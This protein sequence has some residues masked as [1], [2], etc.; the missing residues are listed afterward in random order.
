MS[1]DVKALL[2]RVCRMI[3]ERIKPQVVAT[4][5]RRQADML[6][7][8]DSDYIPLTFPKYGPL[9]KDLPNFDFS[10]Q[11]HDPGMSLYTQLKDSVLPF[12]NNGADNVLGVRADM[13]VVNGMSLFGAKFAIPVHTRTIVTEYVPKEVLQDFV[14]P[15]DI[16]HLGTMPR[17]IEHSQHHLAVLKQYGLADAI[18]VHHC[19]TQGPFDIAA[20]TRGHDIFVD[21]YDDGPFVHRLMML[22]TQAYVAITKLCKKIEGQPLGRGNASGCWMENGSGRMCADSEILVS[23]ELHREFIQPYQ[24]KAFDAIGGGWLH[25]C[26]GFPNSSR[27]EGTHLNPNYAAVRGL[28]GLNWTTAGDWLG[29]MRRLKALGLVHVGMVLREDNETLEQYFRRAL[30]PYDSRRGM[31]L[32]IWDQVRPDEADAALDV[33]HKVQ[34]ERFG[35]G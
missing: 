33:W 28:H 16:S 30:S 24:Q 27:R 10:Q 25:Y 13:G 19:D 22:C 23:A 6:A 35:R 9:P 2:D 17:V 32:Q 14:L 5:R 11:F 21:M 31:I 26:G 29:E 20:Q 7:K 1:E 3:A 34:D 18:S 8:R 12:V 15:D 4:A